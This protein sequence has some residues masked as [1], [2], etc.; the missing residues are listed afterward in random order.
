[1]A[2]LRHHLRLAPRRRGFHLITAKIEA[3]LPELRRFEVGLWHAFL[4]HTSASLCI[5]ENAHPDVP[6]DLGPAFNEIVREDFADVH[7]IEGPD[8]KPAHVKAV[9]IGP[10]VHGEID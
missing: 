8:D 4:Q 1:M 2:W 6:R 7:T 9:M 10:A 5:N 3:A